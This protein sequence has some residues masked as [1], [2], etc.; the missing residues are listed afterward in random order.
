MS[1]ATAFAGSRS[2]PVTQMRPSP[3][4]PIRLRPAASAAM[5]AQARAA[6]SAEPTR[7]SAADRSPMTGPRS[8]PG[9]LMPQ[10]RARRRAGR[11]QGAGDRGVGADVDDD[12]RLAAAE[13]G[14][15]HLQAGD[16]HALVLRARHQDPARDLG[17][18]QFRDGTGGGGD[19]ERAAVPGDDRPG[20]DQRRGESGPHRRDRAGTSRRNRRRAG[21]Q[22][23]EPADQR[24][25]GRPGDQGDRQLSRQPAP[26]PRERSRRVA[27]PRRQAPVAE[28]VE[29]VRRARPRNRPPRAPDPAPA[30]R[31]ARPRR[32]R[33]AT[34]AAT[35]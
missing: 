11:R 3:S 22:P 19:A 2:P 23:F 29:D 25:L 14:V 18:P 8:R 17:P 12:Q 32:A 35:G 24:R 5:S 27:Q 21:P 4:T 31:R 6:S 10:R 15:H 16:R 28:V 33:P 7:S 30:P 34:P 26:G 20:S 9:A 13:R 1:A